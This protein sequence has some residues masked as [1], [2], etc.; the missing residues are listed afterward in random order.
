VGG[1]LAGRPCRLSAAGQHQGMSV[2]D[3]A[4]DPAAM[5]Y[6]RGLLKAPVTRDPAWPALA[7]ASVWAVAALALAFAIL[8]SPAPGTGREPAAR[9]PIEGSVSR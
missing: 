6:A 4:L 2:A 5:A 9:A 8:A 7:A 3:S 1:V